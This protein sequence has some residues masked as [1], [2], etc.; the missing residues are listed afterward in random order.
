METKE[1]YAEEEVSITKEGLLQTMKIEIVKVREE[2]EKLRA[3]LGQ[4]MKEY[5]S[6]EAHYHSIVQQ[7][8]ANNN[9]EASKVQDQESK[10]HPKITILSMGEES[11]GTKHEN[12]TEFTELFSKSK[13][14]CTEVHEDLVLRLDC[15]YNG[16]NSVMSEN[17]TNPSSEDSFEAPKDKE[18]ETW[19]PNKLSKKLNGEDGDEETPQPTVKRARVSVR[20]RCDAPTMND[21]CQWRKYGQKIAKGNPCPRG[22]Y[23]CTVVPGCPVRKQ[24]QRCAEDPAILITTY[25]GTHNHP[26]PAAATA[27]AST[28]SAA[29]SM[30]LSGPTSSTSPFTA[31]YSTNHL[32]YTNQLSNHTADVYP[33]HTMYTSPSHPTITLDLTKPTPS[34]A[35]PQSPF[36]PYNAKTFNHNVGLLG[37]SYLPPGSS[38]VSSFPPN[39][40]ALTDTLAKAI[41][42]NPNFQSVLAAAITSYVG[43]Q[44]AKSQVPRNNLSLDHELKWGEHL[45]L[46]TKH[47]N[48]PNA[49]G[50]SRDFAT[51]SSS[52]FMDPSAPMDKAKYLS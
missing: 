23:R 27:M 32:S 48:D 36:N 25:E 22:Y 35:A 4:V 42:T 43:G 47:N 41:A 28:T 34:H 12:S 7:K 30:L 33:S 14:K 5:K 3:T 50:V 46:G 37:Q 2:N 39:Q 1:A 38:I 10:K 24:V 17:V 18:K 13:E 20:A 11:S 16:S 8:E 45:A 51:R 26:L 49:M 44:D 21:G 52:L 19:P 40:S 9:F 6:L 29:A 15:K 31:P